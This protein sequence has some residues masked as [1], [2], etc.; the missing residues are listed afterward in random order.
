MADLPGRRK[1]CA[2]RHELVLLILLM[3]L[4]ACTP[5]QPETNAPDAGAHIASTAASRTAAT[6]RPSAP[7]TTRALTQYVHQGWST[8]DGLPYAGVWAITQTRDGY[9]WIGTR[10][11]LSRFDGRRFVTFDTRTTPELQSPAVT[12]LY[13]DRDG[14][15]WAGTLGGLARFRD[16]QFTFYTTD[17]GLPSD[18]IWSVEGAPDGTLWIGTLGGLARLR[19]GRFTAYTAADGLLGNDVRAVSVAPDGAVWVGTYGS[20][21]NRLVDDR[22]TT[23]AFDGSP[24][25]ALIH[26]LHAGRDGVWVGVG[27]GQANR[28]PHQ[29]LKLDGEQFAPVA[30]TTPLVSVR[31]L[32]EEHDGA[33][34][35]GT[36]GGGL[37][38]LAHGALQ[39]FTTQEGLSDDRVQA[40]YEDREGNVWVGTM[41]GLDLLRRDAP[42]TTY[43]GT[44]G[45]P[46]DNVRAV[47][48]D[49][50]GAVWVATAD[51][52][53][54]LDSTGTTAFTRREGLED[55][56][57]HALWARRNGDLWLGGQ[58]A[59]TRYADGTF[60]RFEL[61]EAWPREAIWSIV[62]DAAGHLWLG[63]TGAGLIRFQ[64][65]DARALTTADGLTHNSITSLLVGQTGAL[66]VGTANGL[67]VV[68]DG[69]VHPF[70]GQEHF[71]GLNVRSMYE[72]VDGTLW[73]GTYGRG[74]LRLRD[75]R[76]AVYTTREGLHDDG[77]WSILAD[78]QGWLWMSSD[79][80]VFRVARAD[81]EAVAAEHQRLLTPIAYG[82][83]D[84]IRSAEANGASKPSGWRTRDGRMWFATQQGVVVVDPAAVVPAVPAP[85]VEYV[86][87]QQGTADRSTD[88]AVMLPAAT[89]DFT[90]AYTSLYF[91]NP[92]QLRF[93]YRLGGFTNGWVEAGERREAAFTNVPPGSYAFHVAVRNGNSGWRESPTALQV[94]VAP[95]A[96]ETPLFRLL[97]ALAAVALAAL[98]V[99][100][101]SRR[102]RQ[103]ADALEALVA[104]RTDELRHAKETTE[105]QALRLLELNTLKSRFFANVSH[106]FRTPL[107]LTLGPLNDMKAGLYGE[108]SAPMAQQVDLA[109]RNATRVLDLIN[110]ILEVARLEA[111]RTALHARPLDL[112][113]FAEG[114]AELFRTSAERKAIDFEVSLPPTPVEVF[115]DPPQLEKVIVNLLSN[116]LKFTPEGGAVRVTVA[117]EA[118]TAR[119][120]VRDSGP[121]I[122]P[123]DLPHLFDRFYQVNEPEQTRL[124]T[125]IG[126]ALAKEIVDLHGGTLAVESEKGFGS[127]FTLTLLLGRAHLTP[128]QIDE[129]APIDETAKPWTPDATRPAADLDDTVIAA[130]DTDD[131]TADRTTILVVDDHPE[132]RAYVR[133]H[134]EAAPEGHAAYRVLE[135]ADGEAGL[136]LAK[137]RL[138]DLVLSDVMMPKLDGLGLCRALKADTD[139]DFI[140]VIL[141]T[142]KAAPEDRLEGLGELADD[143]LTKPFDVA[144]LRAR[145]ANL[146]TVRMRLRERFRQEGMVRRAGEPP[147]AAMRLPPPEPAPSAADVFLERVREAVEVHLSDDKFSVQ[148]LADEVGL[149]RGHL[150]RQLKA[151]VGQ[152]PTDLIRMMR[153]ERATHLL[154]GRVGTVSE[155]AYAV[156]FKSIA[157][158]SDSFLQAYGCRPSTYAAREEAATDEPESDEAS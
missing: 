114:V 135:A 1:A 38:R 41:G 87:T 4:S 49:A 130:T 102:Q 54:R 116:A 121:G 111:G 39:P 58:H 21:V 154:T 156:G 110:Q 26:G 45:L 119:V 73:V 88:G 68:V 100:T 155:I 153:L 147:T 105:A 94:T 47:T 9:L 132:I 72:D 33:L 127:T 53:A 145:I 108:L 138:P 98:T 136:A 124:G 76:V 142:A 151:L 144:E 52:L 80:G 37:V 23:Y 109:R 90:I 12:S 82:V 118:D 83:A 16:G 158:F 50:A 35:A 122:P 79:R 59:V 120:D 22:W 150:H 133:R 43:G 97:G 11:G 27:E 81:L 95:F 74:L 63:S 15:L 71:G 36:Y 139:T 25:G 134:L 14:T 28:S 157:H 149:S 84:G 40:L 2:R 17:D 96:W 112:G 42:F 91:A 152:T 99:H 19:D 69:Q 56:F 131:A 140:P 126:L 92:E 55:P 62:E 141:L 128:D 85:I 20:G 31:A 115:A 44:E 46:H 24:S 57:V 123:A 103:R 143:Y 3:A 48:Q 65:G 93:R 67:N 51:G 60:T 129:T 7:R 78:D 64:P 77:I 5:A 148:R 106:E 107:T 101:V 29:W 13:E 86:Q 30:P 117:A 6:D 18:N 61:P 8:A 66:W 146:I 104:A 34:W 75:G 10:G 125:G 70:E 32:L 113:A 137:A 89:R